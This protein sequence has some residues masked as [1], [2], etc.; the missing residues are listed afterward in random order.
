MPC[1][2]VYPAGTAS[3]NQACDLSILSAITSTVQSALGLGQVSATGTAY[4][5]EI[6]AYWMPH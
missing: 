1:L 4:K 3:Q 2:P 5:A 6:A